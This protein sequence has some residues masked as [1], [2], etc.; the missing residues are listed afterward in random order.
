VPIK[1]TLPVALIKNDSKGP[2]EA[3]DAR[4]AAQIVALAAVGNAL[5]IRLKSLRILPEKVLKAM[6]EKRR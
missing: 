6:E 2:F 3:K 5:G 1:H 4:K